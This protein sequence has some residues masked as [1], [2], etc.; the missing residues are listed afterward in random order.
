VHHINEAATLEREMGEDAR[1]VI[2]WHMAKANEIN[3]KMHEPEEG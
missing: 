3:A 1:A 2:D